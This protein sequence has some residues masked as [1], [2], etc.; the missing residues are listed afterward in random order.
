M[1]TYAFL[2]LCILL[3][4]LSVQAS[5][6]VKEMLLYG[7]VRDSFSK[8]YLSDVLV[9]VLSAA[10]SS[11]VA[12]DSCRDWSASYPESVRE[13]IRRNSLPRQYV[14][15]RINV[16]PGRYILRFTG[17]GYQPLCMPLDIST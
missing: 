14:Q 15:Y 13:E 9:E 8:V 5:A 4:P 17:K 6:P 3:S 11:V 16:H 1:R 12:V 2:L 7:N 10:D